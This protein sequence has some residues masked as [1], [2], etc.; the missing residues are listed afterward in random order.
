ML[1]VGSNA[2]LFRFPDLVTCAG[3]SFLYLLRGTVLIS[4]PESTLTGIGL[5]P[6]LVI[7]CSVVWKEVCLSVA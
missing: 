6:C 2:L 1:V 3:N 7:I 5:H 4:A